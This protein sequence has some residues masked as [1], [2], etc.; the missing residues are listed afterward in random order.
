MSWP[1]L[2][3]RCRQPGRRLGWTVALCLA[4][5]LGGVWAAWLPALARPEF[6]VQVLDRQGKVLRLFTTSD[7]YWR[8]PARLDRID[9]QFIRQLIAIEDKRFWR[10]PGVDPI[11]LLRA[12]GQFLAGGRVVSGASTISMQTVRLLQ[13]GRRS[14]WRKAKQIVQALILESRLEKT[15]ILELYLSLAPYGGNIQG[16][17]AASRQ[18]FGKNA[19][20]LT[21]SE[22]A[23]LLALPQSPE[24]RRPDLHPEAARQSRDRLLHQLRAVGVLDQE[25]LGLA[26]GQAV[27]RQRQPMPFAAP[28]LAETLRAAHPGREQLTTTLDGQSQLRVET[29]ASQV[30][31]NLEKGMTLAVLVVDRANRAVLAHVG[32]GDYWRGSQINL[33]TAIRSPGS[34]CKPFIYGLGFERGLIHPETLINDQPEDFGHYRPQNFSKTFLGWLS[35]RKALQRSLNIPAVLVLQQLGPN[36]FVQRL[37]SVGVRL[38]TGAGPSLPLALGGAGCSLTDLV[39]LYSAL[40][41]KGVAYPLR[42]LRDE[43]S[44]EGRV[45]LSEVANWYVDD[46]LRETPLPSG[47]ASDGE[48]RFK[49]GTSFGFRD[50]W[51]IGYNGQAVVGVWLGRPDGGYGKAET[52]SSLAVPVM[53]QVFAALAPADQSPPKPSGPPAGVLLVRHDQLPKNLQYLGGTVIAG[54]G[55]LP[56]IFFPPDGTRIRPLADAAGLPVMLLKAGGGE[57]P[58]TWLVDGKPLG[59]GHRGS[60]ARYSPAGPGLAR[61]TLIDGRGKIDRAAVWLEAEDG[62]VGTYK[63]KERAVESTEVRDASR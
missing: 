40:A 38:H 53:Q 29:I 23:L 5:L 60:I 14:L 61:I 2:K 1:R 4:V 33:T 62:Q 57:P 22:T 34:T 48:L 3:Q 21:P 18:Y 39:V 28:H 36:S 31:R 63:S 42:T 9:P 7:G 30:Q 17:E 50:A 6:S 25:Q 13:P 27:P 32:A 59:D 20:H 11:A 16:I 56:H 49:T 45:L 43:P 44:G 46:I 8:L 15:A 47:M 51:A 19:E 37:A 10:H 12:G 58:F 41:N 52:G 54:Q 55:N 26:L 24:R 35:I